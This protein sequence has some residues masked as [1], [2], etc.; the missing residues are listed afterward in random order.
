MTEIRKHPLAELVASIISVILGSIRA[1]GLRGRGLRGLKDLPMMIMFAFQLRA[2]A[3]EFDALFA[4]FKAGTLPPVPPA[5][6]PEPVWL[7]PLPASV[8]PAAAPRPA[9][10]P[11]IGAAR[12]RR[13]Q[14]AILPPPACAKPKRLRFGEG[15]RALP[16]PFA[17]VRAIPLRK[18]RGWAALPLHA[19]FVTIT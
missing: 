8:R 3:R 6:E 15:R 17:V 14:A 9:A 16:K 13:A 19:H 18:N 2:M 10:R 1:R 11:R 4:A 5:P 12:P 7:D